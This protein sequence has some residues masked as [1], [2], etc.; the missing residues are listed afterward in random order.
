M[1]F[2]EE[3]I[4]SVLLNLGRKWTDKRHSKSDVE[5]YTIQR[6]SL[7][8]SL[9]LMKIKVVFFKYLEIFILERLGSPLLQI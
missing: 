9:T 4:E 8:M 7:Q 3:V 2:T 1:F 5:D 6:L